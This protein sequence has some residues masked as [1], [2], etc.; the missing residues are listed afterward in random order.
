M[1]WEIS[2]FT[3][4]KA[5]YS[6]SSTLMSLDSVVCQEIDRRLQK[7][8]KLKTHVQPEL[9]NITFY[10]L[11]SVELQSTS[12][13]TPPK[14]LTCCSKRRYHLVVENI[15]LEEN[16]LEMHIQERTFRFPCKTG[17]TPLA[18]LSFCLLLWLSK[19]SELTCLQST[20]S[21]EQHK[22]F[23]EKCPVS[24]FQITST[25]L[26]DKPLKRQHLISWKKQLPPSSYAQP[27]SRQQHSL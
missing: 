23:Y 25:V 10:V 27:K 14:L 3:C 19:I 22:H 16:K 8:S 15:P 4:L 9:H 26:K 24:S 17:S 21:S 13:I 7:K 12:T 5:S 1:Q 2:N 18:L 20:Q 6:W 11:S